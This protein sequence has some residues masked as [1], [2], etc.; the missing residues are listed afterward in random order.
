VSV[1]GGNSAGVSVGEGDS[2]DTVLEAVGAGDLLPRGS[3]GE[4]DDG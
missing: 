3:F 1:G 2:G 4:G